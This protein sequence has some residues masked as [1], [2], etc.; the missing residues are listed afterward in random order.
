MLKIWGEHTAEGE[1][2]DLCLLEP[3]TVNL[4]FDMAIPSLTLVTIEHLLQI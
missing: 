1:H 4:L 3:G 2:T